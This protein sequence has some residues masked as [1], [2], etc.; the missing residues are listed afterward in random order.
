MW[1]TFSYFLNID[2]DSGSDEEFVTREKMKMTAQALV[3]AKMKKKPSDDDDAAP[4]KRR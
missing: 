2:S 4:K 1:I 3:E